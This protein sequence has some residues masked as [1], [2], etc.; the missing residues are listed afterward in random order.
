MKDRT[1]LGNMEN[2]LHQYGEG[3]NRAGNG[4]LIL[5]KVFL[6]LLKSLWSFTHRKIPRA[7]SI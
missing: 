7:F 5:S 1:G 3:Q 6:I 2:V 4:N